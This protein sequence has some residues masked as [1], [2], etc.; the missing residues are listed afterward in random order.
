MRTSLVKP[1]KLRALLKAHGK[2]VSRKFIEPFDASIVAVAI[3]YAHIRDGARRTLMASIFDI[4]PI[5]RGFVLPE[6]KRRRQCK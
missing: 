6:P 3:S 4:F 2:R 5:Q 1:T